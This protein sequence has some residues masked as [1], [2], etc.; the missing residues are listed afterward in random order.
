[1]TKRIILFPAANPLGTRE[2]GLLPGLLSASLEKCAAHAL[3][4]ALEYLRVGERGGVEVR[5]DRALGGLAIV[6]EGREGIMA[7]R[8]RPRT[9]GTSA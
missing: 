4:L 6:H 1:M 2:L 3:A 7:P 8:P 9:P 5:G